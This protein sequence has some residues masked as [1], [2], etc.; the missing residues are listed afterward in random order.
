MAEFDFLGSWSDS[1]GILAAILANSEY[2]LVPDLLYDKPEP[3]FVTTINDSV[4]EMLLDRRNGFLW[5]TKFS[6]FPPVMWRIEGGEADGK[7]HVGLGEGGP[8]LRLVLPA[9]YEEEGVLNLGLGSLYY[10][11]WTTKPGTKIVIKPSPE[12]RRGFKEVKSVLVRHL[13]PL[14]SHPDIW[15]G[16]DANRLVEEGRAR[17]CGFERPDASSGGAEGR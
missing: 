11:K 2:S 6:R 17:I 15:I 4:R 14:K 5:S 9:C 1:W 12:L 16:Q 8:Y 3:L 13:V 7:Y 10:P